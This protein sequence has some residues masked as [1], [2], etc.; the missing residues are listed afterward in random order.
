MI[1]FGNRLID[2]AK[3]LGEANFLQSIKGYDKDN[4]SATIMKKLRGMFLMDF[5]PEAVGAVSKAAGA[6]HLGTQST[7]PCCKRGLPKGQD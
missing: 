3:K 4:V 2:H 6:L 1:L 5:K 7:S